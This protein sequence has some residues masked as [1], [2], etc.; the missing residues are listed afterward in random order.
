MSL[1]VSNIRSIGSKHKSCVQSW[2]SNHMSPKG[3]KTNPMSLKVSKIK[4]DMS[5]KV[6]QTNHMSS[7]VA[8]TNQ[9]SV[10]VQGSIIYV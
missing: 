8:K 6:A 1:R 3:A 4:Y 2:E 9:M 7:K 5:L 10:N